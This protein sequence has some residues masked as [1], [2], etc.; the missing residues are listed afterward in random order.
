MVQ[1][2]RFLI[3]LTFLAIVTKCKNPEMN[4]SVI[5]ALPVQINPEEYVNA[6]CSHL[7]EVMPAHERNMISTIKVEK[8]EEINAY[9]AESG[10][11]IITTGML[12]LIDDENQLA[13]VCGHEFA[14]ITKEHFKQSKTDEL[15]SGLIGLGAGELG[16]LF[17]RKFSDGKI[18]RN[19]ARRKVSKVAKDLSSSSFS[20]EHE[21]ESDH[22][23]IIYAWNAGFDPRAAVSLWEKM[24]KHADSGANNPISRLVEG[25][26]STH[27]Q[28]YDRAQFFVQ[29]IGEACKYGNANLHRSALNQCSTIME[30]ARY[31]A[32][33]RRQIQ[34]RPRHSNL[35]PWGFNSDTDS[36][37]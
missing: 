4:K 20:R 17:A 29:F 1:F 11:V 15:L 35:L 33:Q 5:K 37:Y 12:N 9:A 14:H 8:D 19:D 3:L 36:D 6:L 32:V 25:F 34:S 10:D 16:G 22:M 2:N 13:L 26:L 31:N 24:A 18:N 21:Q 23:G 27:P 30:D 28:S 7:L